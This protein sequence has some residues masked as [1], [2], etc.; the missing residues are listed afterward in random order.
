MHFFSAIISAD[1]W[2]PILSGITAAV[3]TVTAAVVVTVVVTVVQVVLIQVEDEEERLVM[4]ADSSRDK[5]SAFSV[6]W[7]VFPLDGLEADKEVTT[8]SG[9]MSDGAADSLSVDDEFLF[10]IKVNRCFLT[11]K[12]FGR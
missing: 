4:L 8:E 7:M 2:L 12:C 6:P 3:A 11:H 5:S 9:M 10:C 1:S